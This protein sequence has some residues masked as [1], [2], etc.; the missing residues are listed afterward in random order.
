MDLAERAWDLKTL[1]SD[2]KDFTDRWGPVADRAR[3][4]LPEPAVA[5]VQRVRMIHDFRPLAFRDPDLPTRL[6]PDE[7]HGLRARKVFFSLLALLEEPSRAAADELVSAA[8]DGRA[9]HSG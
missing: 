2:Y 7:W 9:L 3:Q 4:E 1:D 8:A 5:L 6:L